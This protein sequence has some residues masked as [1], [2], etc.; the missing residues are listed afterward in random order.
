MHLWMKVTADEYEL[1]EAVA[2]SASELGRMCGV[3]ASTIMS[4]SFKARMR[5]KKSVYVKV[6]IEDDEYDEQT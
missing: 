4:A 6:E 3:S 1:P 2:E 5:G